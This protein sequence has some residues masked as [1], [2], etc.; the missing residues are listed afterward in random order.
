MSLALASLWNE[1]FDHSLKYLMTKKVETCSSTGERTISPKEY[2]SWLQGPQWEP[3]AWSTTYITGREPATD[4]LVGT[5]PLGFGTLY[6]PGPFLPIPSACRVPVFQKRTVWWESTCYVGENMVIYL[7]ILEIDWKV[8]RC[9]SLPIYGNRH[10]PLKW[11]PLKTMPELKLNS[12]KYH[13]FL[14][15]AATLLNSPIG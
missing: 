12:D 1:T 6:P 9:K 14:W 3:W 5:V 7:V 15:R 8:K 11:F 4:N 13:M 2:Y 10:L